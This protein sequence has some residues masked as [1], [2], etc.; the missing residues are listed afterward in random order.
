MK[1]NRKARI[2]VTFDD[3]RDISG[4]VKNILIPYRIPATFYAVTAWS[5]SGRSP[6]FRC[7]D[8]DVLRAL[9]EHPLFEVAS[10]SDTH[11]NGFADIAI[12]SFKLRYL[13]GTA[14]SVGFCSPG[15]RWKKREIQRNRDFLTRSGISYV[16]T[17]YTPR[18][19]V[20]KLAALAAG[21]NRSKRLFCMANSPA[22]HVGQAD[23]LYAVTVEP[24][25]SPQQLCALTDLA[26]RRGADCVFSFHTVT[27][28]PASAEEWPERD[29][30]R[31]CIHLVRLRRAGKIQLCTAGQMS[32]SAG[33]RIDA[34]CVQNRAPDGIPRGG[35]QCSR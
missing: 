20:R 16:Q 1:H 23:I 32:L 33:Q 22:L 6:A 3:A 13:L 15:G 35:E 9:H 24:R 12:G 2:A 18:T 27:K 26:V 11:T 5:E 19:P 21:L 31:F 7:F 14:E 25:Y 34:Q 29:F 30:L 8:T 10:H 28:E 17:A 4:T